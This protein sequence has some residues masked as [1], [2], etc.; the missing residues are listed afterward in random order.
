METVRTAPRIREGPYDD[1]RA[2]YVPM[3]RLF[4]PKQLK[5]A[6]LNGIRPD[7]HLWALSSMMVA[8]HSPPV[9]ELL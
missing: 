2:V 9:S 6:I 1:T 5:L 7:Q 8:H 3:N 4:C